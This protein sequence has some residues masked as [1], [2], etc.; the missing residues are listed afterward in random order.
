MKTQC[1]HVEIGG[2]EFFARAGNRVKT[3]TAAAGIPAAAVLMAVY[4]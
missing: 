1:L 3:K 4:L 2:L